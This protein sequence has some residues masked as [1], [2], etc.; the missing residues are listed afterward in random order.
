[1]SKINKQAAFTLF[2]TEKHQKYKNFCVTKRDFLHLYIETFIK[3]MLMLLKEGNSDGL[4]KVTNGI[5]L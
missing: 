3:G 1:M 5:K 4:L 2:K